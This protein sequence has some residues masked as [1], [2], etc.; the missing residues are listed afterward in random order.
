MT[1][2]P[3]T[4][5]QE[6][7]D[8]VV[9]RDSTSDADYAAHRLV[10]K[11]GKLRR[12]EAGD[13]V[14]DVGSSIGVVTNAL[15]KYGLRPSGI[16][17]VPEFVE[18]ARERY[19]DIDFQVAPAERLPFP[20]ESFDYVNMS[21]LIEHVDDWQASIREAA[22]V[23]KPGGVL[24]IST[25]NRLWPMQA[26]IRHIHG[27]GYLPGPVQ[28]R[29]FAWVMEHRPDWVGHT[30]LPAYHWLTYWQL[31]GALRQAGLDPHSYVQLLDKD[32]IPERYARLKRVIVLLRR[33][34]SA[35]IGL[36]PPAN[37]IVARKRVAA[38]RG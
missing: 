12:P 36:L 7:F 34:P 5:T 14:L 33:A 18:V 17:V 13:T 31:T 19:P 8:L 3:K 24:Y 2:V 29:I 10:V 16:D 9:E 30:H 21:S 6:Y 35:V 23:L 15:R 27:F 20:N 22:R 26:E 37:Q 38:V 28:R 32:D 11:W 4:I 1:V 25:S